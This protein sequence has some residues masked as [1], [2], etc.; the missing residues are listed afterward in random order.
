MNQAPVYLLEWENTNYTANND[1]GPS[2]KS[3]IKNWFRFPSKLVEG[4]ISDKK[5]SPLPDHLGANDYILK[6][7]D[8]NSNYSVSPISPIVQKLENMKEMSSSWNLSCWKY[9][10]G[11]KFLMP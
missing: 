10:R 7:A 8:M 5:P 3:R 2:L 6:S 9:I 4:L 1:E 11:T